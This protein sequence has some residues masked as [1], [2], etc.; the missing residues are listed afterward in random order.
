METENL[1]ENSRKKLLSKNCDIIAA[2]SISESGAGFKTDTNRIT[3]ISKD[4]IREL[5]LMSKLEAADIL[6]DEI[7]S[8]RKK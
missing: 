2:N 5:S 1:I 8:M 7:A 4:R 3:L 6:L